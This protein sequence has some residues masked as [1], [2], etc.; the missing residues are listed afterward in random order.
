MYGT[1]RLLRIKLMWGLPTAVSGYQCELGPISSS[2]RR[3]W[4]ACVEQRDADPRH[5]QEGVHGRGH[6][7]FRRTGCAYLTELA[8]GYAARRKSSRHGTELG[9]ETA[10]TFVSTAPFL[11]DARRNYFGLGS[12]PPTRRKQ[13]SDRRLLRC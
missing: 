10:E 5:L 4:R 12:A 2:C 9:H 11:P 3:V 8:S 6:T 13:W 7:Y 1:G